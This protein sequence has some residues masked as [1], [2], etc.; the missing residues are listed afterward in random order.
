MTVRHVTLPQFAR[1]LANED[2]KLRRALIIGLR[3]GAMRFQG[4]VVEEIDHAVPHPAVDT[5][6]LRQSVDY[7][8]APDGAQVAVTAPHA[9]AIDQGARPHFPPIDPLV[10]WVKRKGLSHTHLRTRTSR[11]TGLTSVHVN[12][13]AT[14]AEARGIAFAIAR[15]MARKGIAPRNFM[16]KAWARLPPLL[17]AEIRDALDRASREP[18]A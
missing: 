2:P 8:R 12:R 6:A 5:G 11:T 17:A 15:T 14:D 16:G 18:P 3:G 7:Q 4:L 9:A 13:A 10:E 1:I